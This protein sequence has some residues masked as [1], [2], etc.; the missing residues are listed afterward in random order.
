[1]LPYAKILGA[2]DGASVELIRV[3]PTLPP[4]GLTDP[5]Y[6]TYKH[7]ILSVMTDEAQDYLDHTAIGF[8]EMGIEPELKV[9][10][11]EPADQIIRESDDGG[12]TMIAMS[13]HGGSGISRWVFGSVTDKVIQTATTPLLIVHSLDQAD[14]ADG[15]PAL[16][17][18]R[19]LV[20][21]DGSE[22]AEEVL[23]H[24]VDMAKTLGLGIVL[25]RVVESRETYYQQTSGFPMD[26]DWAAYIPSFEQFIQKTM[27]EAQDYLNGV[28]KSLE[29]DG[30]EEVE[31]RIAEGQ[32][33]EAI[34][35]AA[36]EMSD[37]LVAM[38]THGR[39]GLGRWIL[40]S[41]AG[42]VVQQAGDPVLLVRATG[43][44][45]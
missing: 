41:V 20:P 1:V 40:G 3:I 12:D 44:D 29:A 8:R 34:I 6:E 27:P 45:T 42:R 35:D 38:T 16:S 10:K 30:I 7:R 43:N 4:I 13:T 14:R 17:I 22:L 9:L 31:V 28:K 25:M 18:E 15:S 21:L 39:S 37:I 26:G 5:A 19:M 23:P 11:G 2:P 24:V 32:P 36:H 33:A